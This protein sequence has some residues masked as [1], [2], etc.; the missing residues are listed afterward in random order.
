MKFLPGR[1]VV[2]GP[3]RDFREA[4]QATVSP[5]AVR[6]F[7]IDEVT[8]V[9]LGAD[10]VSVTKSQ[11]ADWSIIKPAILGTIMEHFIAGT[12]VILDGASEPEGVKEDYDEKDAGTVAAIKDLLETRVRPAVAS[13]GGDV[14]FYGFRDGV[15]YL[16]MQGA[17]AGCPSSSITLKAGIENLLRYFL[18]D[19]AE[20]RE[21]H[22]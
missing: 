22:L 5:L 19:V 6:L 16:Y 2:A 15:V 10:F 1:S 3:S 11:E 13:D 8:G 20:V 21:V 4:D 17:C 18:P 12:P 14:I 9:L 7:A